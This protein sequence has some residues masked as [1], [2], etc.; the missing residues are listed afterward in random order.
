MSQTFLQAKSAARGFLRYFFLALFCCTCVSF[1]KISGC[2]QIQTH[3]LK[4]LTVDICGALYVPS[5]IKWEF[6]R[7]TMSL[8]SNPL[9]TVQ[10]SFRP[11]VCAF[12]WCDTDHNRCFESVCRGLDWLWCTRLF[13]GNT[14]YTEAECFPFKE[15][16]QTSI[17]LLSLLHP[18]QGHRS[19]AV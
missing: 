14:L 5:W 16:L 10:C 3:E 7:S 13:P 17:Y 8:L 11:S 19:A 6:I 1:F 9:E 12:T 15:K 18:V 4:G 2:H